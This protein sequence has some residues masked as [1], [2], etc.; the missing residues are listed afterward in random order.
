MRFTPSIVIVAVLVLVSP[1]GAQTTF[2][3]N[4]AN[5]VDDGTCNVT[6]C[7]LREAI[8]AANANAGLDII[9]FNI[10]GA[11]PHTIQPTA[12]LPAV[13][14]AVII[15]G[16]TQSGASVNTNGPDQ[17]TNAVLQI[18]VDGSN[19]G[20]AGF[21]RIA[22]TGGGSTVKGLVINRFGAG[23][24]V[25]SSGNTIEGNF[26]GTDVG[27][28]AAQSNTGVAGVHIE[29]AANNTIGGSAT[30]ARNILS[31]IVTSEERARAVF[32]AWTQCLIGR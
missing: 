17:G 2:T 26:I 24:T 31:N 16:Y 20:G 23:I 9:A 5:D 7:S 6:H 1:L 13:T 11:G 12:G 29:N 25:Q 10:T 27:G 22:S 4:S 8:N 14:D 18:E 32:S 15:D 30:A 21:L 3:V 19:S 28:T